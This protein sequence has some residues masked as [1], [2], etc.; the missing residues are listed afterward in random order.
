MSDINVNATLSGGIDATA[1]IANVVEVPVAPDVYTGEYDI[2]APS[3]SSLTLQTKDKLM[4]DD[5]TIEADQSLSAVLLSKSPVKQ[6]EMFYNAEITELRNYGLAYLKNV[7]VIKLPNLQTLVSSS[8]AISYTD[9]EEIYLPRISGQCWN[10]ALGDNPNLR[11][12]DYGKQVISNILNGDVNLEIL[13]LRDD[14]VV[15][16]ANGLPADCKLGKNGAGGYVYV[17]QA[18]LASYRS[19]ASW[20]NYANVLEFRAIEGSEYELED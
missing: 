17:P 14:K 13:I 7:R 1:Q 5:L 8:R 3:E 10:G 12:L 2:T 19:S 11:V 9:A 4:L 20:Q 6:I 15:K 16:S 18:L